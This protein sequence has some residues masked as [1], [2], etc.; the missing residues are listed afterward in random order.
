MNPQQIII[1]NIRNSYKISSGANES[2][3]ENFQGLIGKLHRSLIKLA[4]DL[5]SKETHFALE[6]IQN[7]DDNDYDHPEPLLKFLNSSC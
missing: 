1:E 3:R 2:D 7:A 4:E 6:L 5:Y